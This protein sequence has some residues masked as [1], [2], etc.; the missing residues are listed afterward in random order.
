MLIPSSVGVARATSGRATPDNPNLYRVDR[1][2]HRVM[3]DGEGYGEI[4]GAVWN[5]IVKSGYGHHFL[6]MPNN[7]RPKTQSL[8]RSSREREIPTTTPEDEGTITGRWRTRLRRVSTG[9]SLPDA[10][11]E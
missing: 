9:M 3:F 6:I 10:F 7:N 1:K 4:C 11:E 8:V 2:M 5:D